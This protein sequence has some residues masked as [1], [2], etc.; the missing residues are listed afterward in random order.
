MILRYETIAAEAAT[1]TR[2]AYFLHGIFGSGRNWAGVARRLVRAKPEF[3][4]RLIDLRQHGASQNFE[5][6]HTIAA[7]AADLERLAAQLKEQPS[8][9][10]GHSFGGKVA[11]MYAREHG[12]ALD[13]VWLIDSTPDA[14][15]PSGTAWQM[16]QLVRKAPSQYASRDELVALLAQS[17]IAEPVGQWMAT[18][19]ERVDGV[20][21][22]RFDLDAIEQLMNDFFVVDLWDIVEDP[23]GHMQVHIVKA[24][25]SS[26]LTPEAVQRIQAAAARTSRVFFHEVSGGHWVNA[27]NPAA[28]HDLLVQYLT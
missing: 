21:R 22:W 7:S 5:P 24:E 23:P 11:L 16:L 4:V 8:A 15:A 20:F 28:L 17:G 2:F 9:V 25:E 26:V 1:P 10:L 12:D 27:D 13:Q 18:N 6:P 19:L 14:R 3:G